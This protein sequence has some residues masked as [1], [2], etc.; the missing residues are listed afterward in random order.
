MQ[1][2]VLEGSADARNLVPGHTGM[3]RLTV[4]MVGR[5]LSFS[6]DRHFVGRE[7]YAYRQLGNAFPPLVARAVATSVAVALATSR[8]D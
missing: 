7:T 1:A 2:L 3:P 4:P 6:A 8:R 5:M